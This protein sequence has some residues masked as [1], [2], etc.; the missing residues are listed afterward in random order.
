MNIKEAWVTARRFG[1]QVK[2]VR[3]IVNGVYRVRSSDGRQFALKPMAYPL[4]QL[5]WIDSV[6]HQLKESGFAH[7]SWRDRN[8]PEGRKLYVISRVGIPYVLNPWIPGR[9]PAPQSPVEMKACG[10]ALAELH[11]KGVVSPRSPRR[12]IMIGKWPAELQ[13]KH[14]RLVRQIAISKRSAH[15]HRLHSFLRRHGNELL[16]YSREAQS[17]LGC[18]DYAQECKS[19][20]PLHVCHGDGGPTN[21]T[22]N[23]EGVYLIDFETLRIDLRSYD[24]YRVIYNSCKDHNWD[25]T[26]AQHIFD[27]Y[28]TISELNANDIDFIKAWLRFPRTTT[29]LLNRYYV[30]KSTKEKT[31]I[32]A[33][34]PAAIRVERR[35][36]AFLAQLS[37]Y[38]MDGLQSTT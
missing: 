38:Q 17:L 33:K 5:R 12:M 30:S 18:S 29:L 7:I 26:I 13:A 10:A 8:Q 14:A 16:R 27:G 9:W 2:R 21:F 36:T 35:M 31:R 4:A 15:P 1:V 25:F 24:L 11:Q 23:R 37:R 6:L 32:T 19:A 20:R 28:Q 34:L 3:R 22:V